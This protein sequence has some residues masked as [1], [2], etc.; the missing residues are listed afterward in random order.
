MPVYS[1]I[2][3]IHELNRSLHIIKRVGGLICTCIYVFT[4]NIIL[5]NVE[6]D[7]IIN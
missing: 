1:D 6:F 3:S 7:I 2:E 5:N 4:Y